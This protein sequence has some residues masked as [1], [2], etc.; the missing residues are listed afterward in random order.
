MCK[1][2]PVGNFVLATLT[3]NLDVL[4]SYTQVDLRLEHVNFV[5]I[6]SPTWE[7]KLGNPYL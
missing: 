1:S 2:R 6:S 4:A 3:D 7:L 5:L